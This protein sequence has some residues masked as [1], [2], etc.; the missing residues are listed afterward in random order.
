MFLN[1]PWLSWG[2]PSFRATVIRQWAK[3]PH[4]SSAAIRGFP[5]ALCHFLGPVHEFPCFLEVFLL[6]H[7]LSGSCPASLWASSIT[8]V[9]KP[10]P[11]SSAFSG[12]SRYV[13]KAMLLGSPM[14]APRAEFR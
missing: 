3:A 2:S 6:V 9:A 10:S 13:P 11:F 1:A 5:A 4:N 8:T 12:S 14:L 7:P